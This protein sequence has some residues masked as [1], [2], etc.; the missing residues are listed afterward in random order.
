MNRR[1]SAFNA[2]SLALGFAFLYLPILIL[3]VFSFNESRL[4]TVWGG[5]S[6]RWYMRPVPERA[7]D[8]GGLGNAAD[9]V[10]LRGTRDDPRDDGCA[11]ADSLRAFPRTHRLHRNGLCANGHAGGDHRAIAAS[12]LRGDRHRPRLLDDHACPYDFDDV[13]RDRRGAGAARDVRPLS[14]RGGDGSRGAAAPDLPVGHAALDRVP[15][16][17]RDFSSPSRSRSTISSSRVSIRVPAQRP[18]RSGSTALV[19]LGLSPEINALSA[20]LIAIVAIGVTAATL[21]SKRAALRSGA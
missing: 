19:R 18:C 8:G 16:S 20:I 10:R 1:F 9:C 6:V 14:R 11:R 7:A 3:I 17:S 13:L 2:T 15:R 21:L 12:I 5:F 4:V